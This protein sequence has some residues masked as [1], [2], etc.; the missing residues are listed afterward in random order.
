MLRS[1][2]SGML[3]ATLYGT[4][5][6]QRLS[7][8]AP[9]LR[10]CWNLAFMHVP[11]N[12]QTLAPKSGQSNILHGRLLRQYWARPRSIRT[13]VNEQRCL[14][15]AYR[16][17]RLVEECHVHCLPSSGTCVDLVDLQPHPLPDPSC[18]RWA[19]RSGTLAQVTHL[20]GAALGGTRAPNGMWKR[21][22]LRRVWHA[23][24]TKHGTMYPRMFLVCV[25]R[26]RLHQ[27]DDAPRAG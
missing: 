12:C 5:T 20:Y 27:H 14:H 4:L 8:I 26:E 19:A 10:G 24:A 18:S 9:F 25:T 22:V 13:A 2:L 23:R 16:V 21:S 11:N 3:F 15:V 1:A 7:W 6:V 17:E